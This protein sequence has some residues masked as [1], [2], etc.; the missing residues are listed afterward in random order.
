MNQKIFTVIKFKTVSTNKSNSKVENINLYSRT[1]RIRP[2]H[3]KFGACRS[4]WVWIEIAANNTIAVD[5]I[6]IYSSL[7]THLIAVFVLY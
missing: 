3:D 2:R 4:R 5:A 7:G 1:P 6:A